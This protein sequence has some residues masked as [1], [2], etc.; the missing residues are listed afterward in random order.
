MGRFAFQEE[1]YF[2]WKAY[3]RREDPQ[4]TVIVKSDLQSQDTSGGYVAT[5]K[6]FP[7]PEATTHALAK[8]RFSERERLLM[9]G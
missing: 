8:G 2:L 5:E 4:D 7:R 1:N 9:S 3:K 6:C